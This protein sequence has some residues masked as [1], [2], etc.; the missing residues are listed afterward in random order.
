MAKPF[1]NF[2]NKI[3]LMTLPIVFFVVFMV[4]GT[5][6]FLNSREQMKQIKETVG[7]LSANLNKQLLPFVV[8]G[9]F[10]SLSSFL[11]N[12]TT[13][14]NIL[15]AVIQDQSG[16]A[17]AQSGNAEDFLAKKSKTKNTYASDIYSVQEY[18]NPNSGRW[19]MEAQIPLFE[20]N[21]K[22]GAVWIGYAHEPITSGTGRALTIGLFTSGMGL[23]ISL[24][25]SFLTFYTVTTPVKNFIKD[26]KII[27]NGNLDH[28]VNIR[29]RNEIGQLAAEFN[30]LTENLKNT[31]AEKD[32]YANRLS[33][34]NVNLER[35][36]RERTLALEEANQA[37]QKAYKELQNAQA[38]LVQSEKMASLGQLVAGIAHEVNNPV[39]FIYGNMDHLTEYIND[40]KKVLA[41]F[42]G[43]KSLNLE[44]KQQ[45][46]N[47]VQETDL[48][49]LLKDLDKL[50]KSCKN[51]AE[52][53]KD[54]VVA[55]R[56]FSRLDEAALKDAD[57]HEGIDST[58]E[59]LTH[60]YKNR[61]TVHKEYGNIPKIRCYA[62]QL[63]QV[64]MN[65]LANASQAIENN[66]DV[67]IKTQKKG[68]NVLISI[69]DTGNGISEENMK[70]LFTPFFT[71]KPIGQ[72]AGLGLSIS[73]GI[74]E[75]HNGLIWAESKVGAGTTF[76]I[77]LPLE[78]PKEEDAKA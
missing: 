62:S 41:G 56:S 14:K 69:R 6:I 75:K 23:L 11:N 27:A 24:G 16:K 59:I 60:N 54:I 29:S 70:K 45:I 8:S 48:D 63:N 7:T 10:D 42:M 72:G 28:K 50:I 49:F 13:D 71:T 43:L 34:L 17:V 74:I 26:I 4:T 19:V 22:Y 1:L 66:G 52:R 32:D 20:S 3:F 5:F 35:K 21:V 47:L 58:L 46:D 18:F 77:E 64:F 65:L 25:L 31:L 73:Y 57:I 38:Q 40:I 61:I 39:S 78:G 68:E 53:T 44:E 36:V 12:L 9:N 55:L 37:L 51:G 15:Y 33:D 2:R 67:W 30:Q 76:N